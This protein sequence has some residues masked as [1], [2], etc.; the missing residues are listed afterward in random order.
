MEINL[1]DLI[2]IIKEHPRY[3][4]EWKKD[5]PIEQSFYIK[6]HEKSTTNLKS[7]VFTLKNGNELVLDSDQTGTVYGIEII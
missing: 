4:L 1:K 2:Q 7:D 5:I 6:F 3:S